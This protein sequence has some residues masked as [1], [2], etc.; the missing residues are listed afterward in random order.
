MRPTLLCP[1]GAP[2]ASR[3]T[4]PTDP[5]RAGGGA[6]YDSDHPTRPFEARQ[7]RRTQNQ[8]RTA[9]LLSSERP[10]LLLT[11]NDYANYIVFRTVVFIFGF[12]SWP[13]CCTFSESSMNLP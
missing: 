13:F 3:E 9:V 11:D 5:P 2:S 4:R 8:L 6:N 1:A 10:A 12:F 7:G